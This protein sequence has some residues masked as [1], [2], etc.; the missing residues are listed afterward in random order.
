MRPPAGLGN[1]GIVK[2]IIA[3]FYFEDEP[4]RRSASKLLTRDEARRMAANFAK[5]S[6]VRRPKTPRTLPARITALDFLDRARQ[7]RNA[8]I[9][10]PDMEGLAPHWPKNFD[11]QLD[12]VRHEFS[13]FLWKAFGG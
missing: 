5:L 8:A 2:C 6:D 13:S 11:H 7:F 4:G 3:Y 9:S 12:R 10:F 1:R